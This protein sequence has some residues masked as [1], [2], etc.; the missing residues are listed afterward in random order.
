MTPMIIT[1]VL[2]SLDVFMLVQP[3]M[4]CDLF[5]VADFSHNTMERNLF[6]GFSKAL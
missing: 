2:T 4:S 1:Q 5:V 6:V 3:L